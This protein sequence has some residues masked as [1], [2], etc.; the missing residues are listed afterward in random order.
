VP[1]V[2]PNAAVSRRAGWPFGNV[3]GEDA[4]FFVWFV[5]AA[6]EAQ[7]M[8]TPRPEYSFFL[9]GSTYK[10]RA[11]ELTPSQ[12]RRMSH[13]IVDWSENLRWTWSWVSEIS[14]TRLPHEMVIEE[15]CSRLMVSCRLRT[16]S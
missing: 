13:E 16:S 1:P 2:A 7:P 3:I 6:P 9:V 5:A 11:A 10:L 8:A 4:G 14:V 15:E 12:P